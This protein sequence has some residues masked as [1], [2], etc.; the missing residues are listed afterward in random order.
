MCSVCSWVILYCFRHR[1]RL[2]VDPIPPRIRYM[3]GAQ[4]FN[5]KC[6]SILKNAPPE[7]SKLFADPVPKMLAC[8]PKSITYIVDNYQNDSSFVAL[9]T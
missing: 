4:K 8:C 9:N 2:H 1:G 7:L 3:L 6:F 5:N